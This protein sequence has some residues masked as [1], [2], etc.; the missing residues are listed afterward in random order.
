MSS[1]QFWPE[2]SAKQGELAALKTR[3]RINQRTDLRTYLDT[4]LTDKSI[5]SLNI[6]LQPESDSCSVR[7][8]TCCDVDQQ[9]D[10]LCAWDQTYE[11]LS[12]GAFRGSTTEINLNG[13][14]LFREVTQQQ[15]HQTGLPRPGCYV[16]ALPVALTGRAVFSGQPVALDNLMVLQAGE[17]LDFCAPQFFDVIALTIPKADLDQF[18]AQLGGLE[19]GLEGSLEQRLQG[20]RVRSEPAIQAS[21]TLWRELLLEIFTDLLPA[22]EFGQILT[23]PRL[24]QIF[25]QAL[26]GNLLTVIETL[27]EPAEPVRSASHQ[28][29]V[30]RARAYLKAHAQEPITIADLCQAL[31]VS[32]RTLQYSFQNVLDINPIRYLKAIRLNG[33]RRDL[34]VLA[35]HQTTVSDIATKW[36]FWH[37]SRFATEYRQMF[38]ELPSHTLH[39]ARQGGVIAC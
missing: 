35:A 27:D 9:A 7:Q 16:F 12:A 2:L 1:L 33:A 13:V 24:R 19:G 15:I 22:A 20:S 28:Q 30:D 6:S 36:G 31:G 26:L 32:R 25:L 8:Q 21:L 3:A 34:Q 4:L 11:Q 38:G 5:N 29:L 23:Q 17:P 39:R 18:A 10:S 37:F 14:Q